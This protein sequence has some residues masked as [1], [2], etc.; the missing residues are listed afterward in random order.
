[1][2]IHPRYY[3]VQAA[4]RV[5]AHAILNEAEAKELTLAEVVSILSEETSRYTKH[6][7][8]E[9]RH[10]GNDDKKGDEA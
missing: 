4:Q 6:I 3:K 2:P 9:E 5:I 10:P 8:R 1:M 7:I